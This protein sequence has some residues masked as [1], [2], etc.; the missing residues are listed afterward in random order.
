MWVTCDI[1]SFQRIIKLK[2]DRESER[3]G[4]GVEETEGGRRER[5]KESERGQQSSADKSCEKGTF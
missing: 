4:G 2:N 3:G 5:E 1:S